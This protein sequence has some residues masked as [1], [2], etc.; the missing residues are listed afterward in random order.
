MKTQITRSRFTITRRTIHAFISQF[1]QQNMFVIPVPF[2]KEHKSM[3]AHCKELLEYQNGM[4]AIHPRFNKL[5]T[6]LRTA[7]E[8]G[9]GYLDKEATSHDDLFDSFRMSLL[10]WH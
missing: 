3:L 2:S 10:F 5:I 6:A 9:E 4:V 1:L 7:V 8:N